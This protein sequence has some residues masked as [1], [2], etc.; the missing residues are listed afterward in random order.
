MR[1]SPNF[2][3]NTKNRSPIAIIKQ[4]L[5]RSAQ[6]AIQQQ[7][8]GVYAS[9]V[10]SPNPPDPTNIPGA[11]T[12]AAP[13]TDEVTGYDDELGIGDNDYVMEKD[14]EQYNEFGIKVN[15]N[16]NDDSDFAYH[17]LIC[18]IIGTEMIC[19]DEI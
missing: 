1:M 14:V 6:E 17:Q 11:A 4:F 9:L 7:L 2:L 3:T 5:Q 15:L 12:A 19:V 13:T 16:Y 8:A 10:R 18:H